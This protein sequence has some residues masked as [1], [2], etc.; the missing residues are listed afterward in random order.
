MGFFF[1]NK[2]LENKKVKDLYNYVQH[3]NCALISAEL[4]SRSDKANADCMESLH[5]YIDSYGYDYV[6]TLGNWKYQGEE[7]YTLENSAFVVGSTKKQDTEFIRYMKILRERF[8]QDAVLLSMITPLG[9]SLA[10]LCRKDRTYER[11]GVFTMGNIEE[12]LEEA[13]RLT[14]GA[15]YTE[16][17]GARFI[18]APEKVKRS[19]GAKDKYNVGKKYAK[20]IVS[21]GIGFAAGTVDP[22]VE[23]LLKDYD[24]W[25]EELK[26]GIGVPD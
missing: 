16:I 8:K 14:G 1:E 9:Y 5:S 22:E 26:K 12:I 13:L 24:A 17:D 23:A 10:Y 7:E 19:W 6:A 3:Y 25:V 15:G 2:R 4:G 11:A 18:F 20:V 21:C